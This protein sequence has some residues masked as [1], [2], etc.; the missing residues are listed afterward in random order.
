MMSALQHSPAP[1]GLPPV[2]AALALP[3][4]P[5]GDLPAFDQLVAAAPMPPVLAEA[6]A[7]AALPLP[8]PMM[9][10]QP[11][12][13]TAPMLPTA[14]TPPAEPETA[15]E[16]APA[17]DDP[18]TKATKL[19]L[20]VTG[21]ISAPVAEQIAAQPGY[22]LPGDTRAPKPAAAIQVDSGADGPADPAVV[23]TGEPA[24]PA[25]VWTPVLATPAASPAPKPAPAKATNA[26]NPAREGDASVLSAAA[27]PREATP[28]AAIAADFILPKTKIA[29]AGPSMTVIFTPPPAQVAAGSF[30][31][32]A[33]AA[34]VAERVLDMT[35]DDAWIDQLARDIAATKSQS[36]DISFR[37][38]PRHLGRLDVAMRQEEGGVSL[39][40]D[41][42]H[43][44]TAT[45]VHAAQSR[46][47]EDLR[48]QG[49]RVAGAEVTCTPG[50]TGRGSQQ[51]TGH[52][53][54]RGAAQDSAH[55]IE[56]AP[57]RA[58]ARPKSSSDER[59]ATRV[60]F[61]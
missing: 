49:V 36:G 4:S 12:T 11:V 5:G 58:E 8:V 9:P 15:A 20:A 44:A 10:A 6:P 40:L 18:A 14:A 42:Q 48:Q 1:A 25:A 56:I 46:L 27:K 57:E 17:H 54:G 61:A 13:G 47:V 28:P 32:A 35:S 38:M 52:G 24:A 2:F 30:A 39:K 59:A 60:R 41:T 23:E 55:L 31:E 45:V 16:A 7:G 19:L 22:A 26:A 21:Q 3:G 33:A 34:P 37:L 43:E 53:Q 51:G 29:E 50:E